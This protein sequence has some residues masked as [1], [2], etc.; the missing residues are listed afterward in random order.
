MRKETIIENEVTVGCFLVKSRNEYFAD[1]AAGNDKAL[2]NFVDALHEATEMLL[3]LNE[4]YFYS[5]DDDVVALGDDDSFRDAVNSYMSNIEHWDGYTL[6][7][8]SSASF[9]L[10]FISEAAWKKL[11]L[12]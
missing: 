6:S 2:S 10:R 8:G 9:L 5:D 12:S 3:C 4:G 11:I 1:I 7:I